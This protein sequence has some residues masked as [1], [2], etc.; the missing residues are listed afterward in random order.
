MASKLTLKQPYQGMSFIWNVSE[1][2][3]DNTSCPNRTTD[4]DLVKILLGETIRGRPPGWLHGA[5]RSP[6]VV[7]GLMDAYTAYWIRIFNGGHDKSAAIADAGIISPARGASLSPS[8]SW[9]I[10]KLN[11]AFKQA[12]ARGWAELPNHPQV[13]A[14]LK[15]ELQ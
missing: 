6:L 11:W 9:T 13:K 8:D 15:A 1:H 14:T 12:N 5:C 10:V 7:N 4:V 3:G 2:V